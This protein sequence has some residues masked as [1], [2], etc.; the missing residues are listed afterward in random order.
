MPNH[1]DFLYPELTYKIRGAVFTVW[2]ELGPVYK[3][4]VYQKALSRQFDLLK[5]THNNEP[6]IPIYFL[7]EKVGVYKPDFVVENKVIVE[8]KVL[9]ELY[10]KEEKQLW[11]YLKGTDYK[12]AFLVNFGG[13]KPQIKRWIYDK[14]REKYE[15]R[16]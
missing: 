9:P 10:L 8:L 13:Q 16:K 14:A 2:R 5:L 15:N 1:E 7:G 4:S 3:E 11:Y 6:I 12:I